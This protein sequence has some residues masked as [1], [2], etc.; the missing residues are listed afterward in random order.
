MNMHLTNFSTNKTDKLFIRSKNGVEKV[1]NSKWSLPFL[2]KH[3]NE[4]FQVDTNALMNEIERVIVGTIIAGVCA[5]RVEHFKSIPTHHTSYELY[6]LDIILD[7]NMKPYIIEV[8]I[9]PAMSGLDSQLD[10]EI[11][12]RLML[13]LLN[14]ARIIECDAMLEHPC[15]AIDKIEEKI[16]ESLTEQRV[17]SV[18]KGGV[19]PWISP[20]FADFVYVRDF[21]E[22]Y[23]R[24]RGFKL[25]FPVKET[26]IQY[27]PCFD[28]MIYQ[29]LVLS[30]W[31]AKSDDEKL[32]ILS[33]HWNV[34]KSVMDLILEE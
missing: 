18:E 16:K 23:S 3:L 15:P 11:K 1:E 30:K 5:I 22:E 21:A 25:I 8:N 20:V 4:Q 17:N 32:S 2:L 34:Y 33:T 12:T 27:F 28:K 7:E 19:D 24:R 29:D 6:G 26:M 31:V 13:E 14:M 9:S 10:L